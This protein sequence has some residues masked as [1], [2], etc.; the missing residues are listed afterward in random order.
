MTKVCAVWY[1]RS[2][3]IKTKTQVVEV[4]DDSQFKT[5][6]GE[7]L[8]DDNANYLL[9]NYNNTLYMIESA[10]RDKR[11]YNRRVIPYHPF[12]NLVQP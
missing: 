7:L 11:L 1:A 8:F 10:D 2:V 3:N 4:T 5:V 6:F 12:S 9:V